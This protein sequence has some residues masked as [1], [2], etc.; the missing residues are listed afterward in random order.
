MQIGGAVASNQMY[1]C[2]DLD[3]LVFEI[4]LQKWFC[5]F[6]LVKYIKEIE[7]DGYH[8][9]W[10]GYQKKYFVFVL[11]IKLWKLWDIFLDKFLNLKNKIF[12]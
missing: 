3:L 10:L 9:N 7:I 8:L 4:C 5:L 11:I 2:C 12:V 6:T 1:L